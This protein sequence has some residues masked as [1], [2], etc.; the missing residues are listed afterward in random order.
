[1]GGWEKHGNWAV[2]AFLTLVGL[3]LLYGYLNYHLDYDDVC[4]A[5][6]GSLSCFREWASTIVGTLA[7]LFGGATLIYLYRQNEEQKKQTS[8]VLGDDDPSLDVIEHLK[9]KDTLVIRIV[10]WNRRAVFVREI[11]VSTKSKPANMEDQVAFFSAE[12]EKG[13]IESNS[14]PLQIKGWE[15][16]QQRPGFAR[17]D[18]LL[19]R[20]KA[21][22]EAGWMADKAVPFPPD[23]VVTVTVQMLGNVHRIFE[24]EADAFPKVG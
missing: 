4:H 20:Q 22:T 1:M 15:D 13:E 10:N 8:F 2:P 14:L 23:A 11:V 3:L 5:G 16:R 12:N 7:V 18:L 19:L 6:E 24:I 9:E 17:I 21:G